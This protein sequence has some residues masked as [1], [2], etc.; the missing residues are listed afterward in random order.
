MAVVPALIPALRAA[1]EGV[2]AG[3]RRLR[4]LVHNSSDVIAVVDEQLLIRWQSGAMQAVLGHDPDALLGTSMLDLVGSEDRPSLRDYVRRARARPGLTERLALRVRHGDGSFRDV[5][6]AASDHRD[7]ASV[8]GFVLTLRDETERRRLEEELRKL[9]SR[10]EREALYDSL[11]DL[12]NRRMLF[13]RLA[14]DVAAAEAAGGDVVVMLIDLDQFKELND[15]LGHRA[16]DELLRE[17]GLRLTSVAPPV[18]LV[19]RLGGDEFAVLLAPGAGPVEAE[20]VAQLLQ[21]AI[22]EPFH[23]QGMSLLVRASIGIAV[24]PEHAQ[25]VETLM[26]RADVAMYVAKAHGAGHAFYATSRDCARSASRSRSTTS[27]PARRRWAT[28]GACPCRSSS[29]TSPS[30]WGWPAT[31]STSPSC[32]RSSRSPTT[33]ASRRS[34]RA[35]S[36]PTPATAC[37]RWAATRARA[38]CWAGRCRPRTSGR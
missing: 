4:S 8:G 24:Y 26:Q 15:T 20:Q 27:G 19:A 21:T 6:A 30:S 35:S 31:R 34:P 7:D 9:A 11:T 16:G 28:C 13:T 32:G 17:I 22:R 10:L 14:A 5:D 36:P 1:L 23:Y 33:S 2:A 25:D 38:F 37:S 12:P 3:E 29:S 18:D